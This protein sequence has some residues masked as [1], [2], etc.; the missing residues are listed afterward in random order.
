MSR[1]VVV[2]RDKR[3]R[4]GWDDGVILRLIYFSLIG[5]TIDTSS[6]LEF[7]VRIIIV[8]DETIISSSR[9]RVTTMTN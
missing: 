5:Y 3:V 7:T 9:S 4:K 6:I 8:N 1:A 2:Q